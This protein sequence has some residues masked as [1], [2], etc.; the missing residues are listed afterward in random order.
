MVRSTSAAALVLGALALGALA[1]GALA[2][3]ALTSVAVAQGKMPAAEPQVQER[4]L[5]DEKKYKAATQGIPVVKQSNDPWAGARDVT[6][7]PTAATTAAP[8]SKPRRQP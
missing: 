8:P 6:P 7:P 2:L 3:G 5:Y 1:L 4:P